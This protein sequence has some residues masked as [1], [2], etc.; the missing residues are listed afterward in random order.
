MK[1]PKYPKRGNARK[2]TRK[3]SNTQTP[4]SVTA[5]AKKVANYRYTKDLDYQKYL[6][7]KNKKE[8]EKKRANASKKK[9]EA[10][11][12]KRQATATAL[13][14]LSDAT[15]KVPKN[16]KNKGARKKKGADMRTWKIGSA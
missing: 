14:A 11:L 16:Y 13:K 9:A 4:A 3:A 5:C 8:K 12:K 6:K 7:D 2:P 1:A 10:A 15:G